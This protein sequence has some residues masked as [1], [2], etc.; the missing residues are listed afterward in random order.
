M[1][2]PEVSE[3]G[4]KKTEST[5]SLL[6]FLNSSPLKEISMTP[7]INTT[8]ISSPIT[9][10]TDQQSSNTKSSS[11]DIHVS[12]MP[13]PLTPFLSIQT[14]PLPHDSPPPTDQSLAQATTSQSQVFY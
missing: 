7:H 9:E 11:K 12:P 4:S 10:T 14:H 13:S 6:P 8:L 3:P 2:A 1:P 5:Q